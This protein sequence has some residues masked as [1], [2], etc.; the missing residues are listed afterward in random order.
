MRADNEV[1]SALP[2]AT[3]VLF[4]CQDGIHLYEYSPGR[5]PSVLG[6]EAIDYVASLIETAAIWGG[7]EPR[8]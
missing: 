4:L 7:L 1:P 6:T 3:D 2:K 8:T 5:L